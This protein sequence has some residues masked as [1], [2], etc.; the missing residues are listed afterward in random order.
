MTTRLHMVR[1]WDR[2]GFVLIN[3]LL[4]YCVTQL[5]NFEAFVCPHLKTTTLTNNS[6][7]LRVEQHHS[8]GCL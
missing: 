1:N 4:F 2:V 8:E 7:S 3:Q 6:H 5:I